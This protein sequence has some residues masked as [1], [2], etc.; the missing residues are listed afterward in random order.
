MYTTNERQ[1]KLKE[2]HSDAKIAA[3]PLLHSHLN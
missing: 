3:I 2:G 1:K